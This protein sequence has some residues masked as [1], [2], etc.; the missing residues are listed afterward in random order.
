[1]TPA[2]LYEETKRKRHTHKIEIGEPI[3]MMKGRPKFNTM[4]TS[5]DT[6]ERPPRKKKEKAKEVSVAEPVL[7]SSRSGEVGYAFL[8]PIWRIVNFYTTDQVRDGEHSG[9]DS[10]NEFRHEV[11]SGTNEAIGSIQDKEELGVSL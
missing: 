3:Q 8:E 11:P 2:D 9:E 7:S 5:R 6:E 4:E 1:V 10:G